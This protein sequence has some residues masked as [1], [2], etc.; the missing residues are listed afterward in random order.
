MAE[1]L[2][3][4]RGIKAR[5]L[6]GNR[7][8]KGGRTQDL[9]GEFEGL[10]E[11]RLKRFND[12][13]QNEESNLKEY[14]VKAHDIERKVEALTI[15]KAHAE[16]IIQDQSQLD[17]LEENITQL[18]TDNCNLNHDLN[19]L[20]VVI[21]SARTT[22]KW[23]IENVRF[24]KLTVEQV[25]GS[26]HNSTSIVH[27]SEDPL[28][29]LRELSAVLKKKDNAI[30]RLQDDLEHAE[31]QQITLEQKNCYEDRINQLQE[32][33]LESQ[34]QYSEC[35]NDMVKAE[36][37]IEKL[38]EENSNLNKLAMCNTEELS[39]LQQQVHK[40]ELDLIC[41]QEKLRTCLKMV[42]NR[43]Q[44]ILKLHTGLNTMQKKFAQAI[45]MEF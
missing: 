11:S 15:E 42:A 30:D 45:D 18:R 13:E 25:F 5:N 3:L 35:Y 7:T 44:A 33:F 21:S 10:N 34:A 27:M 23:E 22:G 39:F 31:K 20:L 38:K 29:D 9:L 4:A 32:D 17:W 40:L 1:S 12:L 8:T 24:K 43:D 14:M 2:C 36:D 26:M 16:T 41:M 28:H 37:D 19:Q 6:T